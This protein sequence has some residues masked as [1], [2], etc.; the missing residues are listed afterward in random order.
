MRRLFHLMLGLTVA[1]PFVA[2]QSDTSPVPLPQA[3]EA[4]RKDSE[5]L[6]LEVEQLARAVAKSQ[7]ANGPF[8][9]TT[10]DLR[11]Q[12]ATQHWLAVECER[13]LLGLSALLRRGKGSQKQ[14][15]LKE[16]LDAARQENLAYPALPPRAT[17]DTYDYSAIDEYAKNTPRE[18][19]SST[20]KLAAYLSKGAKND[21]E[22]ARAIFV[23]ICENMIY[24]QDVLAGRVVESRP[25]FVLRAR[26]GECTAH[27][28][29]FHSLATQ[30]KLKALLIA[31]QERQLDV[32]PAY[33]S[34]TKKV[35]P[36]YYTTH[37][38]NAV[39]LDGRWLV[40]D[41]SLGNTHMKKQGKMEHLG[42]RR[43]EWFLVPPGEAIYSHWPTDAKLQ[44]LDRPV[45]IKEHVSLPLLAPGAF[46]H[47]VQMWP[48]ST[49]ALTVTD[50]V[51]VRA[52]APEGVTVV[53]VL[54]RNNTPVQGWVFDQ[55][56]PETG[57]T[58]LY[59]VFPKTGPYLLRVFAGKGDP[60]KGSFDAI[61]DYRIEAK[62]AKGDGF[63]LPVQWPP[64]RVKGC[65]LYEPLNGVLKAGTKVPF[66]VRVPGA[67]QVSVLVGKTPTPLT[68]KDGVYSGEVM[69]T[70]DNV[71]IVAEFADQPG[72]IAILVG[73]KAE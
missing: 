26:A 46:R 21:R 33:A 70:P 20:V 44:L 10:F 34:R 35:G 58:D 6:R 40:V 5:R 60:S 67:K 71:G 13:D 51:T 73:Y 4:K 14:L 3:V 19:G 72:M 56:D 48:S 41:T 2:A 12:M 59:A 29:L 69:L 45:T 49:P 17:T 36:A 30:A 65:Y 63:R 15:P 53:G 54:A 66:R 9:T 24:D 43:D 18:I 8:H 68:G 28:N 23:W 42:P 38:W 62:S 25:E 50:S 7:D 37:L 39:Q 64:F 31:G 32:D 22:K 57:D 52:R 47:G 27:A 16:W 61:A 55:R 1:V 11:K